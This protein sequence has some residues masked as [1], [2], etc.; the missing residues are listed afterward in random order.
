M[1]SSSVVSSVGDNV[2]NHVGPAGSFV[3]G[4][5][6]RSER[7]MSDLDHRSQIAKE[8]LQICSIDKD[9]RPTLLESMTATVGDEPSLVGRKSD[10]LTP[11]VNNQRWVLGYGQVSSFGKALSQQRG[12]PRQG[13]PA[14]GS[15]V[16]TMVEPC[17]TGVFLPMLAVIRMEMKVLRVGQR[18]QGK[19]TKDHCEVL[20]GVL[21]D[22]SV[23]LIIVVSFF[24]SVAESALLRVIVAGGYDSGGYSVAQADTMAAKVNQCDEICG[25]SYDN[26]RIYISYLPPPNCTPPI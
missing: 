19:A 20:G 25:N 22:S 21:M 1:E 26:S 4:R 2:G 13:A 11:M 8:L 9:D 7:T 18:D 24:R 16:A 10:P 3:A 17:A 15:E 12:R 23:A 6:S 5:R 14:N